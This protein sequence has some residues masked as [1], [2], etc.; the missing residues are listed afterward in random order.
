MSRAEI[1]LEH[2]ALYNKYDQFEVQ[3]VFNEITDDYLKAQFR[4]SNRIFLVKCVIG[5]LLTINVW[6][7]HWYPLPW[8]RNYYLLVLCVVFYYAA[9]YYYESLD[10]VKKH[11]GGFVSF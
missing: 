7:S 2:R 5:L 6:L 9:R 1:P 3:S 10:I 4:K 8:P 11:E